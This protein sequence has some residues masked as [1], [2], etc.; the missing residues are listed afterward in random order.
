MI[1]KT[2][3]VDPHRSSFR[4][5]SHC[6]SRCLT[7]V[8]SYRKRSVV[9][10]ISIY[11]KSFSCHPAVVVL[12]LATRWTLPYRR[13][14]IF[15]W[16][17]RI[18]PWTL[19]SSVNSICIRSS[20][21]SSNSRSRNNNNSCTETRS[22]NNRSSPQF[23]PSRRSI[24]SLRQHHRHWLV[25]Q[26][27]FL[28]NNIII[29][30]KHEHRMYVSEGDFQFEMRTIPFRLF[31]QSS[32]ISR[33][34]LIRVCSVRSKCIIISNSNNNNNSSSNSINRFSRSHRWLSNRLI[35]PLNDLSS[36]LPHPHRL[37]NN[38]RSSL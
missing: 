13:L 27:L 37:Y 24:S 25:K 28:V 23:M 22:S 19:H 18:S 14:I 5:F 3:F 30:Y 36:N 34:R 35:M 21:S 11:W 4:F 12:A 20:S 6:S 32:V 2:V 7:C 10:S 31:V 26:D 1:E 29:N 9:R 16:R 33:M 8:A 15:K 38:L 17:M